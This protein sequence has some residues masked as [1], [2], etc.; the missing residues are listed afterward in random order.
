MFSFKTDSLTDDFKRM[1][2]SE[3]EEPEWFESFDGAEEQ[4]KLMQVAPRK[5]PLNKEK[6]NL[7]D[8]GKKQ[9]KQLYLPIS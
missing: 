9:N 2:E 3:N 1:D 4:I 6:K 5:T 8:T 7:S